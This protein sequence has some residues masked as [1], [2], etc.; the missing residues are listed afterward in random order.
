[1]PTHLQRLGEWTATVRSI[2]DDVRYAARA[3]MLDMVAAVHATAR[4][5]IAG[6]VLDALRDMGSAGPCTSLAD[7][8]RLAAPDAAIANTACSMAHDYDDIVWMGH[9]AHSAVFAALAVG[10][11]VGAEA[12]EVVDAVVVANELAGRLGASSF[13]GP[14][15]GQM[16]TFIHLIGAAAAG[17]RLLRLDAER[18]T[19]AL[20]IALAQPN[21]ALQAAFLR[22]TSKLLAAATPTATGI[23]AAYFARAGLVGAPEILEDPKGFWQ[24]FAFVPLPEMLSDLSEFWVLRTLAIKTYPGCHYFQTAL[25]ATERILARRGAEMTLDRVRRIQVDVT[26]LACEATRFAREYTGEGGVTPVSVNFDLAQSMAVMLCARRFGVEQLE[27]QWLQEHEAELRA[28]S[29]RV[30]V[31]HD[32]QMTAR[33]IACS[34]RVRSARR[35]LSRIPPSALLSLVRRY[36][37][38]YRSSLTSPGEVVG[39][40]RSLMRGRRSEPSARPRSDGPLALEFAG[41]VTVDFTDGTTE[42][43]RIDVPPGALAA[44]SFAAEL[45]AKAVREIV[46]RLGEARARVAIDLVWNAKDVACGA[47]VA[48]LAFRAPGARTA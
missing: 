10:E 13:L 46:P 14:L 33:T 4:G 24:R 36:R 29:A 27:E 23:R 39:I 18:T 25:A 15:N 38:E 28:W 48:A 7:G 1:V 6:P 31:R 45:E 30:E 22:P 17:A 8:A 21:F 35:A 2:P 26:K 42:S 19:H 11:Q 5:S 37:Q 12:A 43:E 3:Q 20:A 16:W 40:A 32:P 34:R 47:L 44:P 41:R 9:T